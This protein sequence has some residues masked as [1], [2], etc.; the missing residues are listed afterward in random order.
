[1]DNGG[2]EE[3]RELREKSGPDSHRDDGHPPGGPGALEQAEQDDDGAD[4]NERHR[5]PRLEGGADRDEI[6]APVQE[7]R[8]QNGE[9][10]AQPPRRKDAD[11]AEGDEKG[12][13]DPD[14]GESNVGG[15]RRVPER[16]DE[17]VE[18]AD[19]PMVV[20]ADQIAVGRADELLSLIHI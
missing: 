18:T 12:E 16:A 9:R 13:R 19:A 10:H 14:V 1:M 4:Q 8:H 20:G 17:N 3:E 2:N 7:G 15:S 11:H 5:R 6:T